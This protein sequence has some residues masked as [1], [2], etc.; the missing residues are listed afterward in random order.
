MIVHPDL[1]GAVPVYAYYCPSKINRPPSH[2]QKYSSVP[3]NIL[4]IQCDNV[5]NKRI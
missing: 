3:N 1:L 4:S 5:R 2:S